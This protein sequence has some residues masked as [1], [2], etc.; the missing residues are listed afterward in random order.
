MQSIFCHFWWDV[1]FDRWSSGNFARYLRSVFHVKELPVYLREA[2]RSRINPIHWHTNPRHWIFTSVVGLLDALAV[3]NLAELR[4]FLLT[5]C[6]LAPESTKKLFPHALLGCVRQ[7]PL[8]RRRMYL[9]PF[10]RVHEFSW[11][12]STRL[13]GR[14]AL[15]FRSLPEI[16]PQI[17]RRY[18]CAEG[19]FSLT[20]HSAMDLLLLGYLLDEA[21]LANRTRRV[22]P[23][24][25]GSFREFDTVSGSTKSCDTQHICRTFFVEP[26]RF[27]HHPFFGHLMGCSSTFQSGNLTFGKMPIVKKICC[28]YFSRIFSHGLSVGLPRRTPASDAPFSR[29][30]ST[31][32]CWVAQKVERLLGVGFARSWLS[33]RKLHGS[34]FEHCPFAFDWWQNSFSVLNATKIRCDSWPLLLSQFSRFWHR[35]FVVEVSDLFSFWQSSLTSDQALISFDECPSRTILIQIWV[36]QTR[37]FS[38]CTDFPRYDLMESFT[39]SI[40]FSVYLVSE[41]LEIVVAN[42]DGQ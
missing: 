1:V 14:V 17:S 34:P 31:S 10:L 23:K 12:V 4:S 32:W 8:V 20:L 9:F 28:R 27:C 37:V 41:V 3:S 5:L 18:D 11:Q 19:N 35:N 16:G 22:R 30:T 26:L 24:N 33:C 40:N 39:W 2:P 25:V 38:I 13:C 6:M 15:V 7:N 29:R 42:S 36:T 21:A